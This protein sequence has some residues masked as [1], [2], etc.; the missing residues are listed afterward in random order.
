MILA[1]VTSVSATRIFLIEGSGGCT[2]NC[3]TGPAGPTGPQGP[4]GT[5][6][7]NG[8]NGSFVNGSDAWVNQFNI[9]DLYANYD[10][11]DVNYSLHINGVAV[12]IID[13][14]LQESFFQSTGVYTTGVFEG[15]SLDIDQLILAQSGV[16][17]MYDLAV[18]PLGGSG[19]IFRIK[20]D[21]GVDV[22]NISGYTGGLYL[23]GYANITGQVYSNGVTVCQSDGTNCPIGGNAS[24]NEAYANGKFYRVSNGS[25]DN[26]SWSEGYANGIFY[27]VS[28]GTLDNRTFNQTLTDSLYV[29]KTSLSGAV[30]QNLTYALITAANGNWSADKA[31]YATN[32]HV[33]NVN[34][35][36]LKNATVASLAGL[37]V[38]D[39]ATVEGVLVVDPGTAT[40]AAVRVGGP[41][42]TYSALQFQSEQNRTR[43]FIFSSVNNSVASN[44]MAFRVSGNEAG[45]NSGGDLSVIR[46]DDAGGFID[47]VMKIDRSDGFVGIGDSTPDAKLDVVGDTILDGGVTISGV[48]SVEGYR[49][50]PSWTNYTTAQYATVNNTVYTLMPTLTT[51]LAASH[52]Y[53]VNCEFLT[54]SAAVTTGEQLRVNTTGT[55]TTVTWSF[56]SQVSATTRTSVQGVSTST[57]AFADTGSAGTNVRDITFLTGYIVTSGSASTITYEMKSEIAAS[58]AAYDTG[59][60][61]QYKVVA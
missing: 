13:T 48:T 55:P 59:S 30:G 52:T 33:E 8:F 53:L 11:G 25:L 29:L 60:Q 34:A 20:D 51:T 22:M 15:T 1:L 37:T 19:G 6:G 61:C 56:N 18:E 47:T 5:N 40:A 41:L 36:A 24:W 7:T 32:V 44:R 10:D 16:V 27:R 46:F 31:S 50:L 12:H 26:T 3:S 43:D 54:F 58:N 39:S 2:G 45:S 23:N 4:A 49:V 42:T 28:N 57:N 14:D 35:T 21:F 38:T 17:T 9:T